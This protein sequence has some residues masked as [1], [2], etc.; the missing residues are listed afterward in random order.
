LEV[1]NDEEWLNPP[2]LGI[3]PVVFDAQGKVKKLT[4]HDLVILPSDVI[5]A[6]AI[7]REHTLGF[8]VVV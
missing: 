1:A 3:Q 6:H 5:A 2:E 7:T 4:V 8:L